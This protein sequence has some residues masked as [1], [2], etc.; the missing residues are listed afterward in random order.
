MKKSIAFTIITFLILAE[1]FVID[2]LALDIQ[3]LYRPFLAKA[4][5]AT[6]ICWLWF[7][8]SK[9]VYSKIRKHKVSNTYEE[10]YLLLVLFLYFI[11]MPLGL[12]ERIV[13]HSTIV[14]WLCNFNFPFSILVGITLVCGVK[15][16]R[17]WK[18]S[19]EKSELLLKWPFKT[20]IRDLSKEQL[21]IVAAAI[22]LPAILLNFTTI[23]NILAEKGIGSVEVFHEFNHEDES[24]LSGVLNDYKLQPLSAGKF[25]SARMERS[26]DDMGGTSVEL[27][28]ETNDFTHC[29]R[30]VYEDTRKEILV[31]S[32]TISSTKAKRFYDEMM[33]LDVFE[34]KSV[35]FL[36]ISSYLGQHHWL[37]Q[38]VFDFTVRS[39]LI[40]PVFVEVSDAKRNHRISMTF[41]KNESHEKLYN[42][43]A[44][45]KN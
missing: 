40:S 7:V 38:Y 15:S 26:Y 45:L 27:V 31:K 24:S 11:T 9:F 29:V 28:C 25:F 30:T 12:C 41:W 33:A 42:A 2:F 1:M 3:I 21:V 23:V 43:F 5:G 17:R 39:F 16:I 22:V 19:G 34:M 8:I 44:E 4:V 13:C 18:K 35:E 32:D 14:S 6:F 20:R 36:D 10:K 37:G